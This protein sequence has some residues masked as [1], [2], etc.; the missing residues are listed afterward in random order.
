L[1]TILKT[2][3]EMDAAVAVANSAD[4][5]AERV[6]ALCELALAPVDDRLNAL[7]PFS[8]QYRQTVLDLYSRISGRSDYRPREHELSPY[9][10]EVA[11]SRPGYYL[12]GSTS[13]TG[14]ILV[15]MGSV[16]QTLALKPGQR[17]LEYGVGEGGIALEAAKC[18]IDV[19]V[20]DI[21]QRY[22]SL[23]DRRAKMADVE[24]KTVLGEFGALAGSNFDVVLFYEAFHHSLDHMA[25]AKKISTMLAP[26]G[27]L[28]L[29]GEP[30]IGPHNEHWR[31]SVP[32][33][34]GL[35]MDGLSYRAIKTY[36]WMELGF[37]HNYLMEMLGRAGYSCEFL[38]SAATD[39]ANC[40]V[41]R[42]CP[43]V[44]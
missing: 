20:V 40:Y 34:W 15:A 23:I 26:G 35:R 16:L 4:N 10:T 25:V 5:E 12:A 41:A 11:D 32:F 39:R 31:S 29:A 17:L 9:L 18:G 13:Y 33:P 37:D 8:Q 42:P 24:V 43:A 7:D 2:V 6:K 19:T 36:G 38:K 14:E 44:A 1:V 21:E 3:A 22:L 27:R 28:I 30:V